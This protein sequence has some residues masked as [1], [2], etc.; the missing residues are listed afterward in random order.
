MPLRIIL[1][2]RHIQDFGI[3]TYIRNLLGGLAAIDGENRYLV[4]CS[5]AHRASLPPLPRNF[6]SV[7]YR[8]SDL[9]VVDHI[10]FPAFLRRLGGNLCHIPLNRVPWFM[11]RPYVVTVHDMS[12]QL[13]AGTGWRNQLSLYR[14]RRGL[15][16]AAKVIAVS[17]ATRRNAE[18]VLGIPH[19]HVR[20]IYNAPDPRFYETP[21]AEESAARD[22]ERITV[23]E[24]YQVTYPFVLYAG[25]IRPQKNLPRLIE[26]F[27]VLRG[28]LAG[29]PRF[30]HLRLIV[31][32]DEI[33]QYPAVR[34]AA[35]QSRAGQS[36][37]FLGYVPFETLR[38][39]YESAEV[40]V[41]PSLHEGFGLP[42]LEAMACGTPVVASNVSSLPEVVGD[43]AIKVSP[44][45]VFEI[46]RGLRDVLLDPELRSRLVERGFLQARKF[47]WDRTARQVLETYLE[48]ARRPKS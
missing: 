40:F 19:D 1:D 14:S 22:R 28:E 24:R 18:N 43:A 10:A 12:R 33:S 31:I 38:A 4:V 20:R 25:N 16:R 27:S 45:N 26:A 15:M 39:F 8:H 34:R 23:L 44:D 36:V 47:S 46:A 30:Q 11:P 42:P 5:P 2:A 6:R 32:G 17:G 3:G 35:A 21:S 29:H 41:F 7:L 13:F 9:E 37:R 48:A